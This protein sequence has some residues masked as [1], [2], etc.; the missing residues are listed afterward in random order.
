MGFIYKITNTVNGKGYVG[1]TTMPDAIQR[2]KKHIY[3]IYYGNGC[4]V[5]GD[6]VK[7]Y[8]EK[9]FKFEV[10]IICFDEDVY[11]YEQSYIK[12]YNTMVPNGYNVQEGGKQ[13]CTFL[14]KTHSE[15]TKKILSEKSREYNNRPEVKDL[16]RQNIVKV[17]EKYKNGD[18]S[19]KWKQA[20]AN[21]SKPRI[22]NK[23]LTEEQ[24][25]KL[26]RFSIEYFADSNNR[27]KHSNALR[28]ANG[29][30]VEQYTKENVFIAT[31]NSIVEAHEKTNVNR[32]SIQS[33]AAGRTK[34]GG[35]FIW[36]Y[37]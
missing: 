32:R 23:D 21:R 13:V 31:Y 33:N 24:R 5:L 37:V 9:A 7:K 26:S 28:K 4:P 18:I 36:I 15:E 29:R 1:V 34:T 11:K 17:N 35:G 14:G 6:A 20:I 16:R 2:F 8:G 19:E 22:K 3:A 12:K 30:K 27:K 25:Q 10:L